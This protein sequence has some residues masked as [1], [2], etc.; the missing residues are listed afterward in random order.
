[1]S[2]EKDIQQLFELILQQHGGNKAAAAESLNVNPVTFWHWVT[3]TRNLPSTLCKA[4]D[5]AGA[6]L[7]I[8]GDQTLQP[9]KKN[10]LTTLSVHA[11]AGAGPA[12]ED[13]E[14]EP[15]FYIAVPEQY[16]HR[17]IAAI[18]ISG[19]SMEPTILDTAVVGVNRE[20]RKFV[21]G[22]I[23]VVRLPYEGL[24]VKRLYLDQENKFFI[25]RSDNKNGDFPDTRLPFDAGD[26]FIFGEVVWV[27][28]SYEKINF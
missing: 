28:Q 6:R 10:G 12:Y 7:L 2:I 27:L 5:R 24:V 8:P 18:L 14:H 4:I 23:Y 1:M 19:A 25:L 3:K 13:E 11:V 9:V 15:K 22:K 17:Y 26:A 21:Q 20:S 16:I